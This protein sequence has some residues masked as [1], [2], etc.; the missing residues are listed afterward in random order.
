[1]SNEARPRGKYGASKKNVP[2]VLIRAQAMHDGIADNPT[3]FASLPISMVAF[4]ALITA[5]AVQQQAV[6]ATKAKGAATLR[7][8]K[9]AALWTAMEILR[10][11]IQSLADVLPPDAAASLIEAA[12]LLLVAASPRRKPLLDATLTTSP[13]TA[14][15]EVNASVLVGKEL[16][17]RK[18]TFHWQ[19]SADAKSWNDAS[20]TPYASTDVTGLAL[21]ATYSFRVCATVGKVTGAWSQ[22]VSLLVH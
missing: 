5:L 7:N 19:W 21:L 12:G 20:S 9:L 16:A 17:T 6:V 11:Y 2:G 15:L 1:M 3:L 22:P 18:V 8:T 14:H 4:L 10:I 13:G